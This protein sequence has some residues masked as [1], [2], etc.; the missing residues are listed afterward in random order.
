MSITVNQTSPYDGSGASGGGLRSSAGLCSVGQLQWTTREDDIYGYVDLSI[1]IHCI[2]FGYSTTSSLSTSLSCGGQTTQTATGIGCNLSKGETA[3]LAPASGTYTYKFA[4]STEQQEFTINFSV[5]ANG[6]TVKGTSS[7][8]IVVTL[9]SLTSYN[10]TYNVNGGSGTAPESQKKY[11]G[12]DLILS[13]GSGLSKTNYS[14]TGWNTN[15][16]GTGTHYNLGATYSSNSTL[17]LYAEW[18]ANYIKPTIT[19]ATAYRVNTSGTADP[20]GTSIVVSFKY[21]GGHLATTSTPTAPTIVISTTTGGTTTQK[22]STTGTTG[23]N[24]Q[25]T[26]SILSTYSTTSSHT[27][28][29]KLYDSNNT[30]GTTQILT[31]GISLTPIDL[32]ISGNNTYMG[33]MTAAS[34]SYLL[35][36]PSLRSDGAI[37]SGGNI[38]T[39]GSITATGSITTNGYTIP[40]ITITTTAPTA[41]QGSNGDIWL[42][43]TT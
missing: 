7:G 27:V 23:T 41:S 17:S 15:T 1:W 31:V 11:Y 19:N 30:T 20:N 22:V 39:S 43:Y 9:S 33:L 35:R 42:V 38:T 36:V 18:T 10:I 12:R 2:N 28:T 32:L 5:T 34:T 13:N 40:K 3:Q 25:Y 26:S 24:V 14:L 29:I 8:S 16:G 21:T 6:N 4:K 37:S